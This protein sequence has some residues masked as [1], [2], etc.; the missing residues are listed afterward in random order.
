MPLK[1][2]KL[3]K[4]QLLFDKLIHLTIFPR[5]NC[6]P[7]CPLCGRKGSTYDSQKPPSWRHLS[8][9]N[10]H[11][12]IEYAPRRIQCKRC[13]TIVTE[14]IPW[15]IGKCQLTKSLFYQ[16][17]LWARELSW[18]QVARLFEVDWNQVKTA[19]ALAVQ[20]GLKQRDTDSVLFMYSDYYFSHSATIIFP[21]LSCHSNRCLFLGLMG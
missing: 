6:R 1:G 10:F 4:D 15:S 12:L 14:D 19:V 20:F 21:F 8:Y 16:L 18:S 5:K 17:A 2:F 3:G 13:H 11:I 9:F 7:I